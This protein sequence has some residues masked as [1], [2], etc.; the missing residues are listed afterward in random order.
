MKRKKLSRCEFCLKE[1]S[2]ASLLQIHIRTHTGKEPN[3]FWVILGVIG[4][5]PGERPFA[6]DVCEKKF[7]SAGAMTKHRRKHTGEKPYV[8]PQV[9]VVVCVMYFSQNYRSWTENKG[10]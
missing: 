9:R 4:T 10:Q 7:A 8:C 3:D 5:F 6:C 1:F 2:G